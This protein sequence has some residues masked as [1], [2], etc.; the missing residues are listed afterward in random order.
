MKTKF[1]LLAVMTM[2]FGLFSCN[3]DDA[4]DNPTDGP[5][6]LGNAETYATIRIAM[7]GGDA[8]GMR[9]VSRANENGPETGDGEEQGTEQENNVTSVTLY[10]F[11]SPNNDGTVATGNC[12]GIL[13]ITTLSKATSETAVIYEA[14][15]VKV[16]I[17]GTNL[18]AYAVVNGAV[19]GVNAGTPLA[20][21]LR[22]T[23]KTADATTVNNMLMT[24]RNP[25]K[26]TLDESSTESNPAQLAVS[27][28]RTAAKIIYSPTNGDVFEIKSTADNTT[29]VGTASLTGYKLV[30]LRND[31]YYFRKVGNASGTVE[32]DKN[33]GG[34]QNGTNFVIDP[35][36]TQK[37]VDAAA[38]ADFTT[39]WFG[40]DKVYAS[41]PTDYKTIPTE[42]NTALGYC[43]ENTM[44]T[45]A[46][47]NGYST[48]MIFKATYVPEKVTVY[49][50]QTGTV[51]QETYTAGATIY[52][53][54]DELYKTKQ[55]IIDRYSLD[56]EG[57]KEIQE[58]TGDQSKGVTCY[59]KYWIRHYRN[60]NDELM[61]I[62][63]FAIVR[64]NAYRLS[65]SK[66]SGIG[67][68][69]DEIDPNTPD[70][71]SKMYLDV[72]VTILPW[73]V[74]NNEGIIL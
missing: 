8:L 52:R 30:N 55:D 51:S 45:E 57:Q 31:A 64:N 21:F 66:V 42:A 1:K 28:E 29:K 9:A 17:E 46:Q 59:Y 60:D 19:P 22:K 34:D 62:M 74:R 26:V 38:A 69:S 65:V 43:M 25:G 37:T 44:K 11:P 4:L 10:F 5:G 24:S 15:K 56:T 58:Y 16:G 72:N 3:N 47:L 39:T 71:S 70:E 18:M 35:Y 6:I 33:G 49:D 12:L 67:E 73:V 36:F 50:K 7:P 53:Y 40:D 68:P 2:A 41:N 27:V 48:G 32:T 63:E 14:K 61:G 13:P 23:M 54:G 20:T